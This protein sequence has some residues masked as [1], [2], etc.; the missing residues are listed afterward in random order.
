MNSL[1]D[2]I[3]SQNLAV[4]TRGNTLKSKVLLLGGPNTYLPFLQQCWRLRIPEAWAERGYE[5]DKT[6]PIEELIFVP[7][8]SDLYAAY[9]AVLFGLYEPDTVGRYRGLDPLEEFIAHGRKAKL[10]ESAGPGLVEMP[11]QRDAFVEKYRTPDYEDAKLEAGKTYRGVIGLDGGSTSS[12]CVFIDENE[13]IL[14][15]VYTLSKGNPIQDM[16]DMFVDMRQWATDQGAALEVTGFGVTG[17]A[18][19][20]LERVARRRREHRRDGRAHDEREALVPERRRHLRHR[21]AGHQG[22]VHAERRREELPP[23]EQLQR[24]Q[25]HAA[26]GDGGPVRPAGEAVRRGR[27]RGAARAEVQLRLRRVP[28]LGPRELPEGGLLEGGAARRPGARPAEEHLAVRGADPAHGRARPR[29]R[30]PGRHAEE[31]GR[32]EGA[33]R[34]HREARAERRGVPPPALR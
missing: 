28:R 23:L 12:K 16:K 14:K 33:G 4:L 6:V 10:G 34:L 22:D 31:R 5:Y 30:A 18:G 7:K 29:V 26:A 2:A 9:G 27:V 19:D 21:R 8:N 25:R 3:V 24:R 13:N 11:A 15:K 17:Y 20:V 1:A 32:A